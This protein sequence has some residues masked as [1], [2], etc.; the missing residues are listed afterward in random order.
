MYHPIPI[1]GAGTW[2]L[3]L[4]LGYYTWSLEP[5]EIRILQDVRSAI[6]FETCSL[7]LQR[8]G[9]SATTKKMHKSFIVQLSVQVGITFGY[10]Q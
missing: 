4:I 7:H 3:I 5:E 1:L 9:M 10:M 2:I 8:C 6:E